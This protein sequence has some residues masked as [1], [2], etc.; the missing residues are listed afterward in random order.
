MTARGRSLSVEDYLQ[1]M[2]EAATLASDYVR[3]MS[4]EAFLDDRKTQQAVIYNILIIGEA[5]TQIINEY[6]DFVAAHP[7]IPWREMRGIR[8]RMAHG[9][10]ELDLAII[11]DTVTTYMDRLSQKIAAAK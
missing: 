2:E 10:Y 8:N 9:Y 11:W 1:H 7:D 5:A 4:K 6:P 3:G